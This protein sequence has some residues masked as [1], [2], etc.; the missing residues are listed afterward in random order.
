MRWQG[1][2]PAH[3]Q[4]APLKHTA[5]SKLMP[6]VKGPLFSL[7]ASGTYRGEFTFHQKGATCVVRP[8]AKVTPSNTTAQATHR[9]KVSQMS[10]G[11]LALTPTQRTNWNTAAVGITSSGR[12]YFWAQWFAQASYPGH[13]PSIP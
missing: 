3:N 5:P 9:T 2:K 8:K 6:K 10:A 4:R 7:Q 12:A 13:P 11:W 1:Y